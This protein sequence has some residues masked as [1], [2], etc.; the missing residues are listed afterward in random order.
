VRR[1]RLRFE[2]VAA[3]VFAVLAL[4]TLRGPGTATTPAPLADAQ[5]IVVRVVDGDTVRIRLDGAVADESLR[6]IGVDTPETVHPTV[7]DECYGA[8]ASAFAKTEL[9]GK[10]VWIEWDAEQRQSAGRGKGRLL[11]YLWT[12]PAKDSLL[13]MFNARLVWE[14]YGS[15]LAVEP[16]VAHET[17]FRELEAEA[18]RKGAG[19]WGACPR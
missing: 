5:G 2:Y 4:N 3:L 14:G 6:L 18:Q 15:A 17:W 8:E 1:R 19:M 12:D 7:P 16:N 11:A 13:D 9:T 10:R